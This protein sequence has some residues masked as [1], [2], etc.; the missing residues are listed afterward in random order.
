LI[1]LEVDEED[2]APDLGPAWSSCIICASDAE[3]ST[4]WGLPKVSAPRTSSLQEGEADSEDAWDSWTLEDKLPVEDMKN[5]MLLTSSRDAEDSR[6]EAGEG[7]SRAE[8]RRRLS[9]VPPTV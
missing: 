5:L 3:H 4:S 8:E 6:T 7:A 9:K 2:V 1:P